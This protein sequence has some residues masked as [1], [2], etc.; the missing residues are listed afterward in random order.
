MQIKDKNNKEQRIE[1]QE[2]LVLQ[3]A[4]HI[5]KLM[6]NQGVSRSELA[7][8]LGSSKGYVTQL[9]DGA[10]MSLRK[11][12]D[13]MMALDS[14]LKIDTCNIGFE[15]TVIPEER[16]YLEEKSSCSWTGGLY[17]NTSQN[18]TANT[19]SLQQSDLRLVG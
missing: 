15:T 4:L 18:V 8:R 6:E 14:S 16:G 2:W 10:N 5:E 13:V 9:L 17:Y 19:Q 11:V 3:V 7:K 1:Q 12:A